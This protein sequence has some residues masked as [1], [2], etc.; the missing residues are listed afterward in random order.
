LIRH[1]PKG[2]LK[3][4]ANQEPIRAEDFFGTIMKLEQ[5]I[6]NKAPPYTE[7]ENLRFNSHTLTLQSNC[8]F[9]AFAQ[10]RLK[11]NEPLREE[12]WLTPQQQGTMIH[13]I[14][15]QF[16]QG[17][18]NQ[19]ALLVEPEV[20]VDKKIEDLIAFQ[21]KK[22]IRTDTPHIFIQVEKKRL[23]RLLKDYLKLE[24]ERAPFEIASLESQKSLYLS[25]LHFTLR[26]DRVDK[27]QDGDFYIIDYKTGRF[28]LS[29]LWGGRPKMPQI[30]LYYL[31][32]QDLN[33]KAL[34]V[35]KIQSQ[36]CEFEGV[37]EDSYGIPGIKKLDE[38]KEMPLAWQQLKTYWT[39]QLSSLAIEFKQGEA[40]V[41]PL[42]DHTC[43]YCHLKPFCRVGEMA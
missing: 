41:A 22:M 21:L 18:K 7:D 16:W 6:D 14:L 39:D 17:F 37:S 29:D 33:P 3:D 1:L 15:E 20:N 43:Q 31:S 13:R 38:I 30:P 27:N 28:R 4:Q 10:I 8:P 11:A 9:K 12:V 40:Q 5:N 25:G 42:E 26:L 23:H 35:T 36:G 32:A 19:A 2:T 34:F 24:K